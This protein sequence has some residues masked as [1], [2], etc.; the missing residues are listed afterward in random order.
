[1]DWN[2]IRAVVMLSQ[3][4]AQPTVARNIIEKVRSHLWSPRPF[5][6]RKTSPP[7]D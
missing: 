6:L 3:D 2:H 1:M 7:T 4:V 5:S